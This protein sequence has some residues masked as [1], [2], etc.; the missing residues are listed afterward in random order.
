LKAQGWRAAGYFGAGVFLIFIGNKNTGLLSTG[1][2]FDYNPLQDHITP[3]AGALS[4]P[5]NH[6]K[7]LGI[8]SR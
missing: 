7:P 4:G 3:F 5:S 8:S 2:L 6:N 1:Y